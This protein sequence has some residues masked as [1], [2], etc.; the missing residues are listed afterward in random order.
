MFSVGLMS[1]PSP[2]LG[3]QNKDFEQAKA[4]RKARFQERLSHVIAH[5]NAH[6]AAAGALGGA[7]VIN[8][9]EATGEV[10]G[11]VP[12]RMDFGK[13]AE[14]AERNASIIIR[15]ALAPGD[16][17]GQDKAVASAA[18]SIGF[19][20]ASSRRAQEKE[21]ATKQMVQN[22]MMQGVGQFNPQALNSHQNPFAKQA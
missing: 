2:C 7:P 11:H 20:L 17:S 14:D 18:S 3:G 8:A 21:R 10:S 9:N 19:G 1:M 16:P 4:E 5:E 15:A 12:I 6:A 22:S 13:T